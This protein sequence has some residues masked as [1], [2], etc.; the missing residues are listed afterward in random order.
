V[1]PNEQH[2]RAS[3]WTIGA[4]AAVGAGGSCWPRP[5]RSCWCCIEWALI[6]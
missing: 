1:G 2:E 3:P 4:L 6:S 5:P